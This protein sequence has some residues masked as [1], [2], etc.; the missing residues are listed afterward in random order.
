MNNETA[1]SVS[2]KLGLSRAT[3]YNHLNRLGLKKRVADEHIASYEKTESVSHPITLK[4]GKTVNISY[5]GKLSN[6]DIE[7]IASHLRY[8]NEE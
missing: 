2:E 5:T 6:K 7:M 4:G 8:L 1:E 3:V